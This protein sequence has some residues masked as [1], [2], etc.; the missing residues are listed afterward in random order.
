LVVVDEPDRS[1]AGTCRVPHEGVELNVGSA[2]D[3]VL[4]S[5]VLKVVEEEGGPFRFDGWQHLG[6]RGGRPDQI[7]VVTTSGAPDAVMHNLFEST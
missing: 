6:F 5:P 4:P 7:A 1:A 3:Q 2:G